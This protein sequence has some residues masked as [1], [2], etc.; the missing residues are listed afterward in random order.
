MS[1]RSKGGLT[2]R[3]WLLTAA[4]A[5]L[6]AA[7]TIAFAPLS[8]GPVQVRLSECM[9]LL[10]FYH[11]K[12]IP[13][14]TAG[15]FLANLASPFGAVDMVCGTAATFLALCA[16]RR[17]TG[18]FTAS[19]CP[20]VSNGIIIGLELAWLT[21]ELLSVEALLPL[22]GWIAAGELLSVTLIGT[23]LFRLLMRSEVLRAYIKK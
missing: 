13:G 5:A 6:Y 15:C 7:L 16:M 8:Y 11:R 23:A 20:V 17:C 3:D 22:M 1:E 2:P 9:V 14:L 12:W 19:L 21:G 4:A 10:A 18:F